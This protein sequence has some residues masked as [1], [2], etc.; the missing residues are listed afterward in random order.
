MGS[1]KALA[2]EY[3]ITVLR[4]RMN[5]YV[6]KGSDLKKHRWGFVCYWCAYNQTK[7]ECA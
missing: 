2:E 1:A 7:A 5:H 4:K 6:Q 3:W